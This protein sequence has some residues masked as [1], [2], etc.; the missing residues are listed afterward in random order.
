MRIVAVLIAILAAGPALSDCMAQRLFVLN[1]FEGNGWY[2]EE[3]GALRDDDGTCTIQDLKLVEDSLAFEIASFSWRLEGLDNLAT[4]E[5]IVSLTSRLDDLRMVPQV[6]DPWVG[7]MLRQQNLRNLIDATLFASWD[8]GSGEVELG[9][10]AIEFP[11]DNAIEL[12]LR[13]QGITPALI[14]GTIG[15]LSA[16]QVEYI[17]SKVTNHGFA[18][19]LIL[20]TLIGR[21][22]SVPGSPDTVIE[23]TKRSVRD[24]VETLPTTIFDAESKESLLLLIEEAPVP[25]GSLFLSLTADPPLPVSRFVASSLT[26]NPFEADTLQETFAGAEV[27][28]IYTPTAEPK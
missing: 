6:D 4:G 16:M 13:V 21:M 14:A 10:L 23:G 26:P 11:G 28:V 8:V 2:V 17:A 24:F 15:D 18:D 27:T 7:Y 25:W 3:D 5:G 1:S 9:T 22:A 12:D 20:G 19:G